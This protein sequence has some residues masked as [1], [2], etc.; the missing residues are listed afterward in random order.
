MGRRAALRSPRTRGG[1][2]ASDAGSEARWAVS[3]R[4]ESVRALGSASL[5]RGSDSTS[6]RFTIARFTI[7]A[8]PAAKTIDPA[9]NPAPPRALAPN[10]DDA[11]AEAEEVNPAS[12]VGW[13]TPSEEEGCALMP[14]E[15]LC[16]REMGNSRAAR[17]AA[18]PASTRRPKVRAAWRIA[19][20]A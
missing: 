2:E 3:A 15:P 4:D 1:R 16:A 7:A 13:M 20:V 11:E 14:L 9:A 12:R 17:E 6:A 18:R 8:P 19:H 10:D 5:A